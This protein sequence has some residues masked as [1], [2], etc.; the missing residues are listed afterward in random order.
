MIDQHT[1]I[2]DTVPEFLH[3]AIQA[4]A[5]ACDGA[6]T[7]DDAGFSKPDAGY[8]R[9][10]AMLPI[11]FYHDPVI[12]Q[13]TGHLAMYYQ[14]QIGGALG[15]LDE[16]PD[17]LWVKKH[18]GKGRS[19]RDQP[20]GRVLLE[21]DPDSPISLHATVFLRRKSIPSIDQ[22]V[23]IAKAMDAYSD[24]DG[25]N[26]QLRKA[27]HWIVMATLL[28]SGLAHQVETIGPE[29]VTLETVVQRMRQGVQ[30]ETLPTLADPMNSL[31]R[32]V[33][34]VPVDPRPNAPSVETVR[35]GLSFT[36]D[37]SDRYAARQAGASWDGERKRWTIEHD[38]HN[39]L[40]AILN[41]LHG[42]F[43]GRLVVLPPD[44]RQTPDQ[45][46]KIGPPM[47]PHDHL[48]HPE[49]VEAIEKFL[50]AAH[51]RTF[52]AEAAEEAAK[53]PAQHSG[54][55]GEVLNVDGHLVARVHIPYDQRE[56]AQTQ[57]KPMGAR[58]DWDSKTW[59]LDLNTPALAHLRPLPILWTVPL[60]QFEDKTPAFGY[61]DQRGNHR[62]R[63]ST[64]Y[65]P[66]LV[67]FLRN[68]I[69]QT[70]KQFDGV[71]KT[72]TFQV[73]TPELPQKIRQLMDDFQ[74]VM[75]D[76]DGREMAADEAT[77]WLNTVSKA[78]QARL[79]DSYQ[80]DSS[81]R[82]PGFKLE[83]FPFQW[84]GMAF[85]DK[86]GSSLVAD[87]CGLGKTPQAIGALLAKNAFPALVVCPSIARLNWE[88]E[89]QKFTDRVDPR[90]VAVLGVGT[91]KQKS[92]ALERAKTADVV[93]VNYD[94]I[95]KHQDFLSGHPF[96]AAILDESHYVKS[97]KAQRTQAATKIMANPSLELKLLLSATPYTNRPSELGPQLKMLGKL[98]VMGGA[99]QLRRMDFANSE[100]LAEFNRR[101]RATCMIRREKREVWKE[102]PAV[103]VG[104]VHCSTTAEYQEHERQW[105]RERAQRSVSFL[106]PDTLVDLAGR[107]DSDPESVLK[108]LVK[109]IGADPSVSVGFDEI[110]RLRRQLGEAKTPAML[111]WLRNFR[112][113][114]P[115]GTKIVL[116][117]N[118]IPVQKALYEGAKKLDM[119]PVRLSGDQDAVTRKAQERAFQEGDAQV[120]VASM[121]AARE[122]ITLTAASHVLFTELDYSGGVMIQC[123][124][125]VIRISQ[126]A[127]TVNVYFGLMQDSLDSNMINSIQEKMAAITEGL[128]DANV[129][130]GLS[131][132]GTQGAILG[133][134]T[135]H[136]DLVFDALRS[137]AGQVRIRQIETPPASTTRPENTPVSTPDEDLVDL[138]AFLQGTHAPASIGNRM[139][140]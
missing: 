64:P 112:D 79:E 52:N 37:D 58:F 72:W 12:V 76:G 25:H 1:E 135:R 131:S 98:A 81:Y 40:S 118:H 56:F 54:I 97:P 87:D 6:R 57:L 130:D 60:E 17:W 73:A 95:R 129:Q 133:L 24:Q 110:S 20:E 32:P 83:P 107:I 109:R 3:S 70:D 127:E 36:F 74:L 138:D 89:F 126:Q 114:T 92:Q 104:H 26:F 43:P 91:D 103:M 108:T 116:F 85:I 11:D 22:I 66:E 77:D 134:L 100:E 61:L 16:N 31:Y 15:N 94:I 86:H 9:M 49:R 121:K 117:A 82:V 68:E 38:E 67:A 119:N 4:V 140:P 128:G 45:G 120:C 18:I 122:N 50:I 115:E 23:E 42:Q 113:T 99:Q 84:A 139:K 106:H 27:E 19:Y 53:N 8:G 5:G 105:V 88:A 80:A 65:H 14:R 132:E 13:Q 125:R 21:T 124:D 101:L 46:V 69:P 29:G 48:E 10:L 7:R 111:D 39:G 47:F 71:S 28:Q 93:I 78:L 34:L 63:M 2:P 123:R 102:M 44:L 62:L 59:N 35:W 75:R 41:R 55:T 33:T 90:A 137:A 96:R 30:D 136:Q 51:A